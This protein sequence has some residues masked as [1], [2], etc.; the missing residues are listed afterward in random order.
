MLRHEQLDTSPGLGATEKVDG[1]G[2]GN[3]Q[4]A[5]CQWFGSTVKQKRRDSIFPD[6]K[7]ISRRMKHMI[8]EECKD[9]KLPR[10]QSLL[11]Y[12]SF[13]DGHGLA[14]VS[15]K[16]VSGRGGQMTC[17]RHCRLHS[18]RPTCFRSRGDKAAGRMRDWTDRG[19]ESAYI[20]HSAVSAAKSFLAVSKTNWAA[21]WQCATGRICGAAVIPA[22]FPTEDAWR[23]GMTS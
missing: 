7:G 6:L 10:L 5:C 14:V 17:R 16:E 11:A 20:R 15:G 2:D 12:L 21:A 9:S 18:G 3:R 8:L 23:V 1:V 4:I 13:G 19:I 22:V